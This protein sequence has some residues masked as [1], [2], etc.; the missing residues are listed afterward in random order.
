MRIFLLLAALCA[1]VTGTAVA[2]ECPQSASGNLASYIALPPSGCTLP[3]GAVLSNFRY[4]SSAVPPPANMDGLIGSTGVG[5][6]VLTGAFTN[7]VGPGA[8]KFLTDSFGFT[9]TASPGTQF[10]GAKA[11]LSDYLYDNG[12]SSSGSGSPSV[13]VSAYLCVGGRFSTTQPASCSGGTLVT[14]PARDAIGVVTTFTNFAVASTVDVLVF[15]TMGGPAFRMSSVINFNTITA[16]C[17]ASIQ[18]LSGSMPQIATAGG[19]DSLI[20]LVHLGV[21]SDTGHADFF[22]DSGNALSIPLNLVPVSSGLSSG[23]PAA[24]TTTPTAA[25][26]FDQPL[27]VNASAVIDAT[28]DPQQAQVVGWSRVQSAG[29]IGAFGIFRYP[30]FKW[31]AVVPL[32]TRN[33]S[34]YVLAFDNTGNLATGV[35]V[36]NVAAT[37][38]NI[39]VILRDDTGA[40]IG[41]ATINLPS[42]GHTSFMLNQQYPASTG[43]RGTVEFQTPGFG[44][45]TAGQISVLGLRANGPALTT[46]PVLSSSDSVGGAIAHTAYHGGFTS[47]FFLVNMGSASASFTLNFFDESGNPLSV[48]LRLPQTGATSTTSSLTQTLAARAMLLVETVANDASSSIV[49][50]AQLTTTGSVSGFEVFKWTTFGQEASV[51][52]ETRT[53]GSFVLV[54]DDTNGLTTGVA[55]SNVAT[56]AAS[57]TTKIYDETGSLLQTST[58]NLAG[59]GHTSFLLPGNY[60]VTANRRGMVEFVVPAGGKINAVGLRAKADGTLTTIPV[61]A[62]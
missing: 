61:L 35:A 56:T 46:L 7:A 60:S 5:F 23:P 9:L 43:K 13:V 28:G 51:P 53:P 39:A 48:P 44:T 49:G 29:A 10:N 20:T 40:Q 1:V 15:N 62:K 52:L 18:A 11:Y 59:R 2:T 17:P 37:A 3:D 19:W 42:R 8:N 12:T 16:P 25:S 24:L 31:E 57:I 34:R 21:C 38:A 6:F 33:A 47:T 26:S 55:L 27:N 36:A 32:E 58:L 4:S 22:D 50:S 54:F 14:L 30:P 41:T 45:L